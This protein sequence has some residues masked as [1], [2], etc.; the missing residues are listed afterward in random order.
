MSFNFGIISIYTFCLQSVCV[1]T[2]LVCVLL[3]LKDFMFYYFYHVCCLRDEKR[4]IINVDNEI[5][6]ITQFTS[7]YISNYWQQQH[8]KCSTVKKAKESRTMTMLHSDTPCVVIG[9][10]VRNAKTAS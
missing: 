6:K 7:V 4:C 9:C 5:T 2:C 3:S 1:C 10:N 8:S